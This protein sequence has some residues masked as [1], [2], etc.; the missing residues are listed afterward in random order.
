[1]L[2]VQGDALNAFLRTVLIVPLTSNL[3]WARFPFCVLIPQGE[4]GL[5]SD[6]VAL[7]HQT[8]VLDATRLMDRWGQVDDATLIRLEQAIQITMD[9]SV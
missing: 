7:C 3:R 4:G 5:R 6:S 9:F 2:V 1:V 8:R